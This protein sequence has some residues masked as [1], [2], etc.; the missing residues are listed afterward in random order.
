MTDLI[1]SPAAPADRAGWEPL[2]LAYGDFYRVTVTAKTLETVWG[3]IHDPVNAIESLLA[4]RGSWP[5]WTH[6]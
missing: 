6:G 4:T 1:V 3:W 2:F 5:I